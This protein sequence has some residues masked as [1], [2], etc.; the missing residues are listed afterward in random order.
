MS[1]KTREKSIGRWFDSTI[2]LKK[3]LLSQQSVG[4]LNSGKG[5]L[6]HSKPVGFM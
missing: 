3:T 6:Y 5:R 1:L 4:R 2:Q